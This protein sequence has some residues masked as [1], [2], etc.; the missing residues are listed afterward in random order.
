[1]PFLRAISAADAASQ[2]RY[3]LESIARRLTVLSSSRKIS[4]RAAGRAGS[5]GFPVV[6]APASA[7]TDPTGSPCPADSCHRLN[8]AAGR[9]VATV[10][11]R[12]QGRDALGYEKL[13]VG[14]P[15]TA[16][17]RDLEEF[18]KRI[19]ATVPIPPGATEIPDYP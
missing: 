9:S 4:D 1:M 6:T 16:E 19:T 12:R 17:Q 11:S 10:E 8:R 2:I 3:C 18:Q 13:R 15:T 7:G 5:L 14:V